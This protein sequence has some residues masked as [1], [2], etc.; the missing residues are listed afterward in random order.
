MARLHHLVG[1]HL[2]HVVVDDPLV[3]VAEDLQVVV[4]VPA[5]GGRV[6]GDWLGGGLRQTRGRLQQGKE[7]PHKQYQPAKGKPPEKWQLV[8]AGDFS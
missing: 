7:H 5:A 4:E 1:I 8:R 3:D 6:L 2:V